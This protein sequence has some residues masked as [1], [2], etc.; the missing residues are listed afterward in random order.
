M[1]SKLNLFLI[2][3]CLGFAAVIGLLTLHIQKHNPEKPV[4]LTERIDADLQITANNFIYSSP[5]IATITGQVQHAE[6]TKVL[7]FFTTPIEKSYVSYT[8]SVQGIEQ[9]ALVEIRTTKNMSDYKITKITR[10]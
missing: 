1:A 9:N 5:E 3:A 7:T 10:L 8:F 4:V 2:I 6:V